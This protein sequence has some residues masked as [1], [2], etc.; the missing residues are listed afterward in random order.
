MLQNTLASGS[1]DA[2]IRVWRVDEKAWFFFFCFFF[3]LW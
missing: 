1:D 3:V 2:S